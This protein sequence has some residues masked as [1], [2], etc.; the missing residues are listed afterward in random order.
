MP[1]WTCPFVTRTL[2]KLNCAIR[3]QCRSELCSE[4]QKYMF[5]KFS[6]CSVVFVTFAHNET[7]QENNWVAQ[8][9]RGARRSR[10]P[11]RFFCI[12]RTLASEC[13]A[14]V[15]TKVQQ[16]LLATHCSIVSGYHLLGG[17]LAHGHWGKGSR[18][19]FRCDVVVR[20]YDRSYSAPGH[21]ARSAR[22]ER[23]HSSTQAGQYG[24][25][26]LILRRC[27]ASELLTLLLSNMTLGAYQQTPTV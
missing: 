5:V 13:N 8:S 25:V 23:I 4:V 15:D 18:D 2:K 12:I 24:R 14:D 20:H 11:V 9:A 22:S 7:R 6:R 19:L 27:P 10:K 26:R 16:E 1:S 21:L 3:I 17:Q